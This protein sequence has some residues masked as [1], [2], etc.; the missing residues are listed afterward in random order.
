M[1]AAELLD[2]ML[3]AWVLDIEIVPFPDIHTPE[4]QR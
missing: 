2:Q 3:W 1:T 4:G